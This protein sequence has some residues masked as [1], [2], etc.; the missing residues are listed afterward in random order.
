MTRQQF[1]KLLQLFITTLFVVIAAPLVVPIAVQVC[2]LPSSALFS[3]LVAIIGLI[4][5]C[6]FLFLTIFW[7]VE[8]LQV[9]R[10]KWEKVEK[11]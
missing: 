2:A 9:G 10:G 8:V 1:Q 3:A 4:I 5:G 11:R 6:T 7:A